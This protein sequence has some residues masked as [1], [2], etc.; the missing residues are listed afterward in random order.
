M[1]S[2]Q[3][4]PQYSIG[5]I[6]GGAWGTALAALSNRAGS[7]VILTT[8]NHN[9][10]DVIQQTRT[11][12]IY[13]PGIYLDPAISVSNTLTDACRGD[14][15]I[16]AMPSHC[17]R[18]ACI[19]ISDVVAPNVPILIGTKGVERGSLLFMSEV[20]ASVLPGNPVAILSGPNFA[21][22]A[23]EGKPSATTIA[24]RDAAI[25]EMLT[26]AVG[27]RLFRPYYTDDIVGTQ[28]GGAVKNVIAIACGIAEGKGLGE[29]SRAAIITRG[30]SEMVRMA[31]AKGGRL[32]TLAGLSG[33]GDLVLTCSSPTSRN[34]AFGVSL[35]KGVKS[36]HAS[37]EGRNVL[38]GAMAA[39]SVVKLA[40]R[41]SIEMPISE[42]VHGVISGEM[43]VDEAIDKLLDRP[44]APEFRA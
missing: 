26:Y 34:M 41:F 4:K 1:P 24:C 32:E 19:V 14:A 10:V 27:G 2:V 9:V 8:R 21:H 15:V 43:S 39:E 40:K 28:V 42:A 20:V 3:V 22:E 44:F 33:F 6:G 29:N 16:F 11:N 30:F 37:G 5:V 12:D 18:S 25:G 13:L 38:E 23:A 7:K 31:L 36:T 35:G 17:V